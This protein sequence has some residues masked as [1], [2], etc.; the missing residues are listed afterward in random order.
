VTERIRVGRL[1]DSQLEGAARILCLAFQQSVDDSRENLYLMHVAKKSSLG[2]PF[3]AAVRGETAG[4]V[5]ATRNVAEK[6]GE[7]GMWCDISS[8]AVHP[9]WR[10]HGIA[11]TLMKYAEYV[12]SKQWMLGMPGVI[13]LRDETNFGL[14]NKMGY[15]NDPHPEPSGKPWPQLIKRVNVL[16]ARLAM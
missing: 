10:R 15:S 13:T 8:L 9:D 4:L 5:V 12:I 16:P 2:V 3:T 7:Q 6:P 1:R 11:R 14:Y